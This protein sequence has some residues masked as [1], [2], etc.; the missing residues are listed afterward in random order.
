M[1][2]FRISIWVIRVVQI[3]Y[4]LQSP[5]AGVRFVSASG[6][7]Y[8]FTSYGAPLQNFD[9]VRYVLKSGKPPAVV[10]SAAVVLPCRCWL[11]CMDESHQRGIFDISLVVPVGL[12]VACT[13]ERVL[14]QPTDDNTVIHRFVSGNRLPARAVGFFVGRVQR[15][16]ASAAAGSHR[17]WLLSLHP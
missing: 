6:L 7:K 8:L 5:S 2:I 12:D 4:E 9:G 3:Q 16:D 1:Y 13:G 10:D 15:Y 11:P 14:Q 17:G